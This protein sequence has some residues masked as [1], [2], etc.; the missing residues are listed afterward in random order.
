[1]AQLRVF[2]QR[3]A[4]GGRILVGRRRRRSV[5]SKSVCSFGRSQRGGA[6]SSTSTPC[7]VSFTPNLSLS[8]S[9]LDHVT[10]IHA[11]QQSDRGA[12]QFCP[13][14]SSTFVQCGCAQPASSTDVLLISRCHR[15]Q[16]V[17]VWHPEPAAAPS[18]TLCSDSTKVTETD[19]Q[20]INY[21]LVRLK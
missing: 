1:M 5:T 20:T 9:H 19:A 4:A 18:V 12:S 2:G 11:K 16:G 8:G 21:L 17:K 10:H 14:T 6:F 3:R 13:F 15:M 7:A